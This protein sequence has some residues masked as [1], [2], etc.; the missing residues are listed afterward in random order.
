[1]IEDLAD[2]QYDIL[3]ENYQA[4][5][6]TVSGDT[7]FDIDVPLAQLSGRVLE[8]AGKI[9]ISGADVDLWPA[10]PGHRLYLNR[11][12][13]ESG[14]FAM[15]GL[16]RGEFM[17][18]AYKPGYEMVRK[19]ISYEG[20]VSNLTIRLRPD[21][22]VEVKAR[23]ASNDRPLREIYAIEMIGDRNGTRL[24]VPLSA[25]GIGYLPSALTG[26]MLYISANGYAH[27][28]IARWDG[29]KLDLKLARS[30]AE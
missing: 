27:A 22:G 28:V 19:R 9:P 2:G 29:R 25:E 26:S 17:L 3:V 7:V 16:E 11:R 12:S 8:E 23:D 10:E 14:E 13:G 30:T 15:A 21:V 20:P 5:A 4:P 6:V 24:E 18:T 1:V